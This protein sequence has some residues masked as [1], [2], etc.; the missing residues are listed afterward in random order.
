MEDF[1]KQLC[2]YDGSFV[3]VRWRALQNPYREYGCAELP[4]DPDIIRKHIEKL[5][6]DWYVICHNDAG[7]Y[8]HVVDIDH[9]EKVEDIEPPTYKFWTSPNRR[10]WLWLLPTQVDAETWMKKQIDLTK[11]CGGDQGLLYPNCFARI[12]YT[13]NYKRNYQMREE[14]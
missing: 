4:K 11:R 6:T 8:M 9:G 7:Y 1:I 3:N 2:S 5:P 12:P 10:Q 14:L 13:F